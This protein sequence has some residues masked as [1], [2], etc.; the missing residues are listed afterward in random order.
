M[1]AASSDTFSKLLSSN[2]DKLVNGVE[3]ESGDYVDDDDENP[4]MQSAHAKIVDAIAKKS[5]SDTESI[6]Q[7][8]GT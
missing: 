3:N 4:E 7:V 6:E 5:S 2:V 1:S 8:S